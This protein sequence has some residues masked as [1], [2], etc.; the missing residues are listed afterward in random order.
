MLIM[1]IAYIHKTSIFTLG[2]FAQ[3]LKKWHIMCKKIIR[4]GHSMPVP[5]TSS[6][7]YC[8]YHEIKSER[9]MSSFFLIERNLMMG[10]PGTKNKTKNSFN[11]TVMVSFLPVIVSKKNK[12]TKKTPKK[13]TKMTSSDVPNYMAN[14]LMTVMC[15]VL[16][17]QCHALVFC[18]I[19]VKPGISGVFLTCLNLY[20]GL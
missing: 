13:P 18:V 7:I 2:A 20:T 16:V 4:R 15:S 5:L 10:T 11:S 19:L 14:I 12:Q 3:K 9:C 6:S 17:S 8:S 1:L